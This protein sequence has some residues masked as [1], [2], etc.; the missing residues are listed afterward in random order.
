VP[1]GLAQLRYRDTRR[2]SR[3]VERAHAATAAYLA[4]LP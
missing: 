1:E 4:G 3:R 2:V